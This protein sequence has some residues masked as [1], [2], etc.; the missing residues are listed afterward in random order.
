MTEHADAHN[1]VTHR[2]TFCKDRLL[3]LWSYGIYDRTADAHNEVTLITLCRDLKAVSVP[4]EDKLPAFENNRSKS[5][6]KNN[7]FTNDGNGN[8]FDLIFRRRVRTRI[9]PDLC[10]Y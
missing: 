6:S 4:F 2:N 8:G 5:K 7:D 1:E 9:K 10:T 3:E